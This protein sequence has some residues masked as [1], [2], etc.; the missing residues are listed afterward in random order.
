MEHFNFTRPGKIHN[1][2]RVYSCDEFAFAIDGA[3]CLTGDHYSKFNS[4]AEWYSNWWKEYLVKALKNKKKTIFEILKKGI[5]KVVKDYVKLSGGKEPEDFP[6]A[7]IC[8]ARRNNGKIEIYTLCDCVVLLKSK[9]GETM[10]IQDPFN[11]VNDGFNLMTIQHF[12]KKEKLS[13]SEAIKKHRDIVIEGRKK[14]NKIGGYWV[15]SDKVEAVDHG[16]FNTIDEEIIDTI[17]LLTDGYAQVFD[18]VSFMTDKELL[19]K[20]KTLKDIE[21]FYN[22][23]Y[24]LQ[25][26]DPECNKHLRFK[27]RDDASIAVMK[28]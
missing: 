23:L 15:L 25:D 20:G 13:F 16:I 10:F 12:G 21:K 1:E 6:S 24:K 7:T 27:L 14:K 5:E 8:I 22:K 18:T 9:T 4:D 28:F 11:C 19:S 26:A 17:M 3:T 2:D